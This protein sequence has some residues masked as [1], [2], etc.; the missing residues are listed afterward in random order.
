M[1][2]TITVGFIH[3]IYIIYVAFHTKENQKQA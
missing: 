2:E 1:L 3:K